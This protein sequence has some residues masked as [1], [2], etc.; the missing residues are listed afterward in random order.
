MNLNTSCGKICIQILYL[1]H[2]VSYSFKYT[3][4]S[5][6]MIIE[7]KCFCHFYLLYEISLLFQNGNVTNNNLYLISTIKIFK[8]YSLRGKNTNWGKNTRCNIL[9]RI[10]A[11]IH[12]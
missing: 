7:I 10:Q 4:I 9:A 5:E 6:N 2:S 1:A 8:I 3:E 12:W 11:V